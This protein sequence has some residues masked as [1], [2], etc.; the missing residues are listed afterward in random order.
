MSQFTEYESTYGY[1]DVTDSGVTKITNKAVTA[2]FEVQTVVMRIGVADRVLEGDEFGEFKCNVTN[3]EGA[4][5]KKGRY[6][7]NGTDSYLITKDPEPRLL[8]NQTLL[9]LRKV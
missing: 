5:M 9:Q 3:A 7:S 4:L 1:Y 2:S 6:L 8:F